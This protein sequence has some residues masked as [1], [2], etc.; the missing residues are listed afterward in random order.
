MPALIPFMALAAHLASQKISDENRYRQAYELTE[1]IVVA[2]IKSHFLL[3]SHSR[4]NIMF[5]HKLFI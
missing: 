2:Y 3:D 5:G 4:K 1:K